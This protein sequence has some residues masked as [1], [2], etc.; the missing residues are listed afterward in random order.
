MPDV[1][2]YSGTSNFTT[3]SYEMSVSFGHSCGVPSTTMVTDLCLSLCSA[4]MAFAPFEQRR[5]CRR[6]S[7]KCQ[8]A[9]YT[10]MLVEQA[11]WH[12]FT[13]AGRLPRCP[14]TTTRS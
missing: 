11:C 12:Y 14:A 13:Y 2:E 9:G 5:Q 7:E 3:S 10:S 1:G 8:M 4:D 6:S